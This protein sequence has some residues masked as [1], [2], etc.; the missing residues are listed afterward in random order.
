MI[1]HHHNDG[2]HDAL[3]DYLDSLA[4]APPPGSRAGELDAAMHDGVDHFFDLAEQAGMAPRAKRQSGRPT[5][6]ATL[7]ASGALPTP[8][9]TS[10]RG[11]TPPAWTQHLHLLSTGLLIAA[12]IA[13]V[14]VLAMRQMGPI[15]PDDRSPVVTA[16]Q[17]MYDPDDLSTFPR[18]PETCEPNG[19]FISNDDLAQRSISDWPEPEYTPA[20]PVSHEQGL[21]IQETYLAYL[22]CEY[23]EFTSATLTPGDAI[24]RSPEMLSYYSDRM[25]YTLL[26]DDHLSS[27]QQEALHDYR[28]VP[29]SDEIMA[30]YPLPVNQRIDEAILELTPDNRIRYSALI[31]A[32]S[33]VYLLPDGRYGAIT[34]T[35]STSALRYPTELTTDDSLAF[36]AFVEHDGQYLIDEMFLVVGPDLNQPVVDRP[37]DSPSRTAALYRPI[38][39]EMC[40]AP[41]E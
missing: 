28:C 11:F 36:V 1:R 41:R 17:G 39:N 29:R 21:A 8:H 20:R 24:P 27:A 40:A 12:V 19:E 22:R 31:F 2:Q 18:V 14:G 7:P 4:G 30:S 15:G 5:M 23:D 37:A 9:R 3:N 32:P 25:R 34:G 13:L 6:N 33:D 35:I 38:E 10:K 16:N 26:D